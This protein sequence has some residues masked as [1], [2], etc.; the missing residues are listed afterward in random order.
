[1]ILKNNS[2]RAFSGK[3]KLS[4]TKQERSLPR[5]KPKSICSFCGSRNFKGKGDHALCIKANKKRL[6]DFEAALNSCYF[7]GEKLDKKGKC[8]CGEK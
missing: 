8:Q 6:K 5:F 4:P 7:C 3:G 2:Y 1:M